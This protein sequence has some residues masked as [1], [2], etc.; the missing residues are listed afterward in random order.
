MEAVGFFMKMVFFRP[1]L[2]VH[3]AYQKATKIQKITA[4]FFK[5]ETKPSLACDEKEC[6]K[7]GSLKLLKLIVS[8]TKVMFLYGQKHAVS[9][10]MY[11]ALK[12]KDMQ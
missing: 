9:R 1:N 6:E 11:R 2:E 10:S 4:T 7:D 8:P 5:F 3:S 12:I